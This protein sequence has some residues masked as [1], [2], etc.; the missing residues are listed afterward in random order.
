MSRIIWFSAVLVAISFPAYADVTVSRSNGAVIS[1]ATES[2]VIDITGVKVNSTDKGLEIILETTLGDKL[3]VLPKNEG[4]NFIADI[5]NAQLRLPTG[6][7][8]TQEKPITGITSV[9]VANFDAKSIRVTVTGEAGL[10]NVEL[11]DD[12]DGLVFGVTAKPV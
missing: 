8:F 1:Q 11:F 6:N 3:K 9:T 12:D 4:N 10:P 5:P 7:T 2:E